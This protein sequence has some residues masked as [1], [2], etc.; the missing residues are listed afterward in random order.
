MTKQEFIE[1]YK[2]TFLA[3]WA[4]KNYEDYCMRGIQEQLETPPVED[5]QFLAEAAWEE[6]KSILG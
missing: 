4:A 1:Q 3:T 6:M 2:V 5:A